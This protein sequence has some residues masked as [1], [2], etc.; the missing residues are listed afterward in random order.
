LPVVGRFV[1]LPEVHTYLGVLLLALPSCSAADAA[2]DPT[3]SNDALLLA[4]D[5]P[6]LEGLATEHHSLWLVSFLSFDL[7][8]MFF[9]RWWARCLWRSSGRLTLA[10]THKII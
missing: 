9:C 10:S 1:F 2:G 3:P 7:A 4:L 6:L 8:N 5:I